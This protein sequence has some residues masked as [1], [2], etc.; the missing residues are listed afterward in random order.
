MK[1]EITGTRIVAGTNC[2]V[3]QG[4]F[5]GVVN[6]QCLAWQGQQLIIYQKTANGT[7]MGLSPP[8]ILLQLPLFVGQHWTWSGTSL[9]SV[10]FERETGSMTCDVTQ[11][12]TVSVPSGT[13]EGYAVTFQL[14]KEPTY[15]TPSATVTQKL[16]F[17]EGIGEVKEDDTISSGDSV[18]TMSMELTQY[19]VTPPNYLEYLV[20]VLAVTAA[21]AISVLLLRRRKS[22]ATT[23]SAISTF[24]E[25]STTESFPRLTPPISSESTKYQ[26]CPHG[27]S[28][29]QNCPLC[30]Q[31]SRQG[32]VKR[33]A[34][35]PTKFCRYCGAEIPR[36][37]KFCEECGK[38]LL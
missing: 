17:V 1:F 29:E 28:L 2:Y 11:Q 36:S 16:W 3:M 21:I 4:T 31:A 12:S 24:N 23:P 22:K 19:N 7:D 8:Q 10:T 33:S 27:Y 34:L 6:E 32:E 13:F 20:L 38:N 15:D 35:S 30:D 18:I 5:Q 26:T 9:N 37:S 25:N 14:T